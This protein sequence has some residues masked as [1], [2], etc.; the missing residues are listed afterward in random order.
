M[1]PL[2]YN[3][4]NYVEVWL[5]KDAMAGI[6]AS[7]LSPLQIICNQIEVGDPDHFLRKKCG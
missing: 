7:L 1:I 2:W 3:Q 4:P 5:E 6:L